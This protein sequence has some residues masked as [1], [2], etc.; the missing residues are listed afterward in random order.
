MPFNVTVI[1]PS[2]EVSKFW[3]LDS[4]P[5]ISM[6]QAWCEGYVK[7]IPLFDQYEGKKA[8]ALCN[9]EGQR[10]EMPFNE[11]A[12]LLYMAIASMAHD[13]PVREALFGNVVIIAV[14]SD[15]ELEEL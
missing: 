13:S 6:L 14:D 3:Y 4:P 2:G 10:L 11:T 5:G 12:Q 9:E 7:A 15:T 1:E 8:V